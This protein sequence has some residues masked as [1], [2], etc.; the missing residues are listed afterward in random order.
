MGLVLT[1]VCLPGDSCFAPSTATIVTLVIIQGISLLSSLLNSLMRP[2]SK[3]D[4]HELSIQV[5]CKAFAKRLRSSAKAFVDGGAAQKALLAL[6]VAVLLARTQFTLREK[7]SPIEMAVLSLLLGGL[8][9]FASMSWWVSR[10]C[11]TSRTP[12][13]GSSDSER[14]WEDDVCNPY[15]ASFWKFG[16]PCAEDEQFQE[17]SPLA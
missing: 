6:L 9:R 1:R 5:E 17:M 15:D 13:R 12:S 4:I 14:P 2:V 8:A 10:G 7:K 16:S 3:K 11:S